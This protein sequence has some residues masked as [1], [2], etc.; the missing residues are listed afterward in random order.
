MPKRLTSVSIVPNTDHALVSD[1]AG[2]LWRLKLETDGPDVVTIEDVEGGTNEPIL[3]HFSV[4]TDFD[5]AER[6]VATADRD[7]KI[8]ISRLPE[9]FVIDAFLLGHRESIA[10][11]KF[12]SSS[13]LVSSSLDGT[14]RLWDRNSMDQIDEIELEGEE[15][16]TGMYVQAGS[17]GM[18]CHAQRYLLYSASVSVENKLSGIVRLPLSAEPTG[19]A[20]DCRSRLWVSA[21]DD[22]GDLVVNVFSRD[23]AEPSRSLEDEQALQRAL[24]GR[25]VAGEPDALIKGDVL[26]AQKKKPMVDN[27][28]GKKRKVDSTMTRLLR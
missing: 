18:I 4:L 11:V 3:G 1:K 17:L 22:N 2:D 26:L 28:K 5:V 12:V 10:Q 21:N 27:W 25:G 14:V 15:I 23:G 24:A 8:R 19:L 13:L 6:A 9:A 20:I 16:A 7:N